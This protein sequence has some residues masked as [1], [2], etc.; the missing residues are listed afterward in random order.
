MR[1]RLLALL[2]L[3]VAAGFA[4]VLAVAAFFEANE[5]GP[6]HGLAQGSLSEFVFRKDPEP[7]P[8]VTFL[9][10][11]GEEVGFDAFPGKVLLVNLWATWCAPCVAEMPTLDELQAKLGS[12]RFEVVTISVDRVSQEESEAFFERIGIKHL[13]LYRD[14]TTRIG[15]D[16]SAFG[17]PTTILI[18]ADGVDVGRITGPAEW[19]SPEAIALV[20]HF[21]E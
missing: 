13:K 2:I 1:L 6:D 15:V 5:N 4:V 21:L 14:P 19:N 11:E 10:P 20:K 9:D 3:S 7:V 17:L 18:D 12:D 16:L 8:A